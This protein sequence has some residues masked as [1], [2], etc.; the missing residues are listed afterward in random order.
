MKTKF[1]F[2]LV[3]TFVV[4]VFFTNCPNSND[5]SGDQ[6]SDPGVEYSKEFWGE[7]IGIKYGNNVSS[8]GSTAPWYITSNAVYAQFPGSATM[9]DYTDRVTMLKLGENCIKATYNNSGASAKGTWILHPK[10]IAA[11]SFLGNIAVLSTAMQSQNYSQIS[12]SLGLGGMGMTVENLKDAAQKMRTTTDEDGNFSF[13]DTI[14]G[15]T[16]GVTADGK[17]VNITPHVD[18]EDIGTITITDGLNFKAHIKPSADIMLAN[19]TDYSRSIEIR[20]IGTQAAS[21]CNYKI[22][23][24][25]GES[26]SGILGTLAPGAAKTINLS[27]RCTTIAAEKRFKKYSVV[28]TDPIN[29]K[30]WNDSISL[31]FYKSVITLTVMSDYSTRVSGSNY[32]THK[33]VG[34]VIISPE[35]TSYYFKTKTGVYTISGAETITLPK[36]KGNYLIAV[37]SG[38][39]ETVYAI[40]MSIFSTHL[41]E[42]SFVSQAA[43][44]TDTGNFE[45]NNT[46]ENA[47][48]VF[49][50]I[51]SYLH[52]G[53]LDYYKVRVEYSQMKQ[54]CHVGNSLS[55]WNFSG[56]YLR[57]ASLNFCDLLREN[58]KIASRNSPKELKYLFTNTFFFKK[59]QYRSIKLRFGEYPGK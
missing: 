31:L 6:D 23:G 35:R 29:N 59:P 11:A 54:V 4:L 25:D 20:N 17:T 9:H 41:A 16:Y 43:N 51:I 36:L 3:I 27:V 57:T 53:D 5:S 34:G 58:L 52:S 22:T 8:D 24:E 14:P 50:P 45:P 2:G 19:G 7:W 56:I 44:F 18:G 49:S 28:I 42:T 1:A 10:R 48:T 12:R 21:G 15:D 55:K 40:D 13:D 26:C 30:T 47:K 33:F 32:G 38:Y 39:T 37:P 46:E